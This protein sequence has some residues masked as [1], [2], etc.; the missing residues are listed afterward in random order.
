[1]IVVLGTADAD[2][3]ELYGETVINGDPSWAGPLAGIAL[4]LPVYHVL[5]QAIAGQVDPACYREHLALMEIA[6]DV[7]AISGTLDALRSSLAGDDR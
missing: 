7:D 1:M 3:T 6:V 5:E 4:R 2:S